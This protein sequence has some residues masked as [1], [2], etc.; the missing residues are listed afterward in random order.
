MND[1]ITLTISPSERAELEA[2]LEQWSREFQRSEE[3]DEQL[4]AHFEQS[5]QEARQYIN[6]TR[7]N[8]EKPCGNR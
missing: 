8:L 7:A 3:E 4:Q 5:L 2:L 1:S 6:L